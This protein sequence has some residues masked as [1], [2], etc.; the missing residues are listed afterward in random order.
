MIKNIY[1]ILLLL[2]INSVIYG[3]I[4]LES[5]RYKLEFIIKGKQENITLVDTLVKNGKIRTPEGFYKLEY[6]NS[7]NKFYINS[8][9]F[10]KDT[11]VIT[12]NDSKTKN[13]LITKESLVIKKLQFEDSTLYSETFY[14]PNLQKTKR[15]SNNIVTYSDYDT[16]I[17]NRFYK[18]YKTFF[19]NGKKAFVHNDFLDFDTTFFI[20]GKIEHI[21]KSNFTKYFNEKG[22][23]KNSRTYVKNESG[24]DE[25]TIDQYFEKNKIVSRKTTY[26]PNEYTIEKFKNGIL[27]EKEIRLATYEINEY[28]IERIK[29]NK[30]YEKEL[31]KFNEEDGIESVILYNSK[32][33]IVK[34][35]ERKIISVR[36][37]KN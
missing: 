32:G 2:V 20:T 24:F 9:G 27:Y 31:I 19:Q 6:N 37:V 10:I 13:V 28:S 1:L 14:L 16:I 18:S 30:I 5:E 17:N 26:N 4:N 3:Q 36:E 21:R 11:I 35:F 33:I 22:E 12:Y 25:T 8:N 29:N 15:Y 7:I 34:E 23:L